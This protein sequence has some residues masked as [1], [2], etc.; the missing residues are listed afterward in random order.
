ME[1]HEARVARTRGAYRE[2]HGRLVQRLRGVAADVASRRPP[3]GGWSVAQ[4]GWHVAAVDA[5]FAA[6]LSGERPS[7]RLPD[8]FHDR[9]W[10][11]IV[12]NIPEKLEATGPVVPPSGVTIGAAL[13]AL[14][15]S[16]A[17]IE[18]ALTVLTPERGARYGITHRIVGTITLY[19]VGEWA[20]AHTIRHNAHAKRVLSSLAAS[21]SGGA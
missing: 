8:G 18:R 16:A 1:T 20:V 13:A 14:E 7:E 4:I 3:D 12:A 9:Q 11:D 5:T 17:K 15:E 2:A 10:S 6:L 19:Q 21:P